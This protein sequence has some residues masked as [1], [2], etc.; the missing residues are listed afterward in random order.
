MKVARLNKIFNADETALFSKMMPSRTFIAGDEMPM[1]DFNASKNRLTLSLGS[2]A[3]GDFK[4]KLMLIYHSEDH[5]AL[6]NDAK[7]ILFVL[8]KW[9]KKPTLQHICLKHALLNI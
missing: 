1:P 8:Y 5:R 2:N 6:R 4:L 7:S 9:N 3:A